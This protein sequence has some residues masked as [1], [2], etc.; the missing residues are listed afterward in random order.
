MALE[1]FRG[2]E[3]GKET[4]GASPLP[5]ATRTRLIGSGSK[6]NCVPSNSVAGNTDFPASFTRLLEKN[7]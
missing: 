2:P 3:G 5:G 4:L 7:S 1:E 6:I